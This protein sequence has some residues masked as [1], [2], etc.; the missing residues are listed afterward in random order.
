MNGRRLMVGIAALGIAAIGAMPGIADAKKK[1]FLT[2]TSP[3]KVTTSNGETGQNSNWRAKLEGRAKHKD[4]TA[5][6]WVDP[7]PCNKH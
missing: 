4:D 1:P 2:L 6:I 5:E 7:Q 3:A